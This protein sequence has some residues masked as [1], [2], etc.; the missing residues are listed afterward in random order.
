MG[1]N[2]QQSP[3]S[4]D[5]NAKA[6]S[7]K[8]ALA[9][10]YRNREKRLPILREYSRTHPRVRKPRIKLE[11]PLCLTCKTRKP[12]N[13]FNL[14]KNV[15]D[16][17]MAEKQAEKERNEQARLERE[18]LAT[19]RKIAKEEAH[20][21]KLERIAYRQT[22]E[23]KEHKRQVKSAEVKRR[24][25]KRRDNG[26]KSADKHDRKARQRGVGG[27]FDSNGWKLL[28][29]LAAGICVKC[30]TLVDKLEPDHVVPLDPGTNLLT[31]IQPL[32]RK[33]NASKGKRYVAD[34]R[35]EWMKTWVY[36]Y[37]FPNLIGMMTLRIQLS[38]RVIYL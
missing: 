3:S 30:G 12:R 37:A 9:W 32:C 25:T 13:Q 6:Q 38:S 1:R 5:E 14:H 23:Y 16:T 10:Y 7:S 11:N 18:R 8:R 29:D 27:K 15:C 35:P 31:N 19:E 20:Q 36:A 2:V 28:Q 33:C 4:K 26:K 21:R 22:D 24:N 34:Y 17:C